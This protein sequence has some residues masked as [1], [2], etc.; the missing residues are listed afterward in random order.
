MQAENKRN[1]EK[2]KDAEGG[3][4]RRTAR[5][6]GMRLK[7][8][9]E[10]EVRRRLGKVVGFAL[11]CAAAYL[12]SAAE[13][14]FGTY[15]IVLAL[16]CSRRERL[17]PVIL[18]VTLAALVGLPT[19]YLYSGVAVLLIRILAVLL[20]I[21]FS[22]AV[23]AKRVERDGV[24]PFNP[25]AVEMR[26]A[27]TDDD[28]EK[29]AISGFRGIFC[30]KTY[31]RL[32][33]ASL[34]GLLCGIILMT[35]SDFS[36]YSLCA[37]VLL[38]FGTPLITLI[39]GGVLGARERPDWYYGLSVAFIMFATVFSAKHFTVLGMPL[40]PC[41]ALLF[42]TFVSS[43]YGIVLGVGAALV[44]GAAFSPLYL[45]LLLISSILFCIVSA[46]K[47]NAG[48]AAV[49]A[50]VVVWCYYIGGNSG[51]IEVLPPMLLSIP[52][53]MLADRYREMMNAPFRK[54]DD[55]VGGVY[56]AE[57]VTEKTKNLAVKE[58][59]EALKEVFASLSETFYKLSDRARRPDILGIRKLTD[60]VF[61]EV[62]EGC[63]NREL[64]RGAEHSGRAEAMAC[65]AEKL[66]TAGV[67]RESDLSESFRAGCV[68]CERLVDEINAEIKRSTEEIIK[69]G[70][71]S[72]FAANYDDIT[73]ILKDALDSDSEEYRCYP[74]LA[75][76]IAQYLLSI[77]FRLGGVVVYGKRCK[78][79]VA[80]KVIPPEKLTAAKNRE[81]GGRIGEILNA[82]MSLPQIEVGKDGNILL[83]H[84][85]P[86]VSATCAH[87]RISRSGKEWASSE[88]RERSENIP[89]DPFANDLDAC[90]D[91][92]DAFVTQSSY[93][94][95]LISDGMG[96]GSQ[97][98]YVS[99]V[100][101]MFI[102]KMLSAGNRADITLRML[103]NVIRSENMGCGS[104]CSATVD[105]LE[106]DLMSGVASFIKSGAA[107]T[108]IAREGTVYK[109]SS[110]TMP[111]GIIKDADARITRFDTRRGDILIMI[112]DG[113]CHDS[114]DCPWLVEYLCA[115]MKKA[116]KTVSVDEELCERL[117]EDILREAVKNSAEGEERDD[118]SVSVILVG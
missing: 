92:S 36:F 83:C 75:E 54:V 100:C 94:Y 24:I 103:N 21:I 108:Y 79:V 113:C 77:G 29:K 95:S 50:A 90:G 17:L 99:G 25:K 15:P 48:V 41:L 45:P 46:V 30:E 44:C 23:G 4:F 56:F 60:R 67:L 73:G 104:E 59:L 1:E 106:L 63:R 117:K 93:F 69:S 96:S 78:R 98:A 10:A 2:K 53:Y 42:T 34:G 82:D 109:I 13:L 51:L 81:I 27:D 97:A 64:C 105:L 28:G 107:P 19:V 14:F 110:R 47:R 112:S 111:V 87:G 40:S 7:E 84:S 5:A 114:E 18:G 11:I 65:A 74:E 49:C 86:T 32:L 91:M 58:R 101:A 102:E 76:K 8:K 116:K 118:I 20:P 55:D 9:D 72:F 31:V 37:T 3:F 71:M 35:E 52:I 26:E 22:E 39:L 66:H 70:R 57:A 62:C 115:Y 43:T 16:L 33:C 80:K 38:T 12:M 61:D 68:R 88:D 85:R 89:V 6:L